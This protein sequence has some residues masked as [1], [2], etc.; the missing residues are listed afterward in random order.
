ME[1]V[2]VQVHKFYFSVD[3]I[4]LDTQ[5]AKTRSTQIPMIFGHP[6]LVTSN[7]LVN[8]KNRVMKLSFSNMT[9][10]LNVFRMC[11]QPWSDDDIHE[12]NMVDSLIEEEFRETTCSNH[13]EVL[14]THNKDEYDGDDVEVVSVVSDSNLV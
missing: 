7:A 8:Y 13:L 9:I 2:L 4:V 1:D 11:N 5:P 6:F 10:E 3:F 14:L 12:V